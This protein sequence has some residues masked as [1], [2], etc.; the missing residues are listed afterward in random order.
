MS[1]S[2]YEGP[3]VEV[4]KV[5]TSQVQSKTDQEWQD[6]LAEN[7]GPRVAMGIGHYDRRPANS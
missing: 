4:E 2:E 3:P 7:I 6:M 1:A 5:K